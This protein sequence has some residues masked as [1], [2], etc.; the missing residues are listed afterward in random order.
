MITRHR[1]IFQHIAHFLTVT[2][3]VARHTQLFTAQLFSATCPHFQSN[4]NPSNPSPQNPTQPH[5]TKLP[6]H[7]IATHVIP[8]HCIAPNQ[9]APNR[10]A[11]PPEPQPNPTPTH[12]QHTQH[13]THT[14]PHH[15][16]PHHTTPHHTTPHQ[17]RRSG[18]HTTP[19]HT[20]PHHTKHAAPA[21]TPHHTTPHHTKRRCQHSWTSRV[22][23][24]CLGEV[25][26]CVASCHVTLPLKTK[27]G[28]R[29]RRRVACLPLQ[30]LRTPKPS[31]QVVRSALGQAAQE[32][33]VQRADDSTLPCLEGCQ[34]PYGKRE[35]LRSQFRKG[36][37][38]PEDQVPVGVAV[39]QSLQRCGT[40]T[41]VPAQPRRAVQ[42]S[43]DVPGPKLIQA[44]REKK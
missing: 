31:P 13:T 4:P 44:Q 3:H 40:P 21:T 43:D 32:R 18:H 2:T 1:H 35:S 42:G 24:G 25:Q 23:G 16:T 33:L 17:A 11:L 26:H 12:T 10:P 28:Q 15:T 37:Q 6:P 34:T 8:P 38:Q 7:L 41:A 29:C 14:T 39:S 19:H 27:P 30:E 5:Q 22:C 20:T 36:L 9:T